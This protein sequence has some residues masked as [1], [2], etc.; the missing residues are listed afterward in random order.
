M[1]GTGKSRPGGAVR[2]KSRG[3]QVGSGGQGRQALEGKG[4]T[5]KAEDRPY[6]P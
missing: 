5:P 2:K 6:H 3:P 4:P 1:K